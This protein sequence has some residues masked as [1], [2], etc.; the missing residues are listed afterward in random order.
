MLCS[1]AP[2]HLWYN[3]LELEAYIRF[4][5]FHNI[6]KLDMSCETSGIS[7]VFK[8]KWFEWV[9]FCDETAPFPDDMLKLSLYLGPSID[10]GLAMTTKIITEN[11]Q[12]LH[13]STYRPLTPDNI[14]KKEG[15]MPKNNSWLESVKDWC[16]LSYPESWRTWG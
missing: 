4:N 8:L 7:Q 1:R 13:R 3:C 2:K 9:M 12:V 11:G 16:S 6:Y 5:T 14:A 15:Q 10:V